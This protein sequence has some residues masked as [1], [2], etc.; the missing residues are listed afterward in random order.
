MVYNVQPLRTAEEIRDFQFW[1][2]RTKF[3]ERDSFLFLFG[4]NNGLRISDI[5][6]LKV[7]EIRGVSKPIIIEQ[8]T[9]KRKPIYIQNL[10]QEIITYTKDMNDEDWLFGSVAK[11]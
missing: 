8:K 1:L 4:I 11:F 5:V 2:R 10:Q 9:G 6:K 3:P 7:R